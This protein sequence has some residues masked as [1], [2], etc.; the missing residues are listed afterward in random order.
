MNRTR[1]NRRILLLCTLLVCLVS[2]LMIRF[3]AAAEENVIPETRQLPRLVDRADLL[4]EL[5]EEELEARLDEISERQQADVVVVTVNSLDGKS[6][7]DYADD[8][9][10]YNGYGIGT[11]KSGILLLVSMEARDW[12]IT[13]TG[14]G[15]RAITDAGLDYISDQFL[16][17]LSDGEYLDAFETYANLCD[18]FLTQAKTGNAYDGDHMP[19]GAY[20]WLKN[21]LIA[22]GSGVV[23]ALLIV[24]GMRRSLKSVK[25]QRSAEN[26][27][28]AGS[29]QVTR[30]QDHFL[31]TRTS[32]SARPKNNS[33]SSGSSTHTSSSGTSHAGGGGKQAEI[34]SDFTD[35]AAQVRQIRPDLVLLDIILPGANGQYILR[36]IR[37][38]SDVPVIMLT[39]KDGEVEEIMSRS[40]G[41][42]DYVTKPYNTTIL[43]LRIETILRR[44][45]QTG[46]QSEQRAS[47]VRG[48]KAEGEAVQEEL[49]D[50]ELRLNLL[51]STVSYH[52]DEVVL[53]KNELAILHCL[54]SRKGQIVSR[55]ELM[56]HLWDMS[57]F[58]DDNT[59]TVNINRLRKR[60]AQIG[61]E[62]KIETRRGQGYLLL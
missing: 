21:L 22:L 17:Y 56:D 16:P 60:L 20:P 42:D 13:T 2:M 39:S 58:V 51:R 9:Y 61:L 24:E 3:S 26:Y 50:E 7:Q 30:R 34:L 54:M 41:A 28:R 6:A 8:F 53:S 33:G 4:S 10:D 52:G 11:D 59:L 27:V 12:H 37:E 5:E 48:E 19:K 32:K 62:N 23:I 46:R 38:K 47:S 35:A 14:F 44:T 1:S 43:L 18:E 57:E 49:Q 40:S 25:M 31:Y 55:D 29:I 15:I 36:Q 45:E